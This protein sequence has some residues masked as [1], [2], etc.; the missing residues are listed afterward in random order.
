MQILGLRWA[1]RASELRP[2]LGIQ[3]QE[4]ELPDKLT[5]EEIV[6]EPEMVGERMRSNCAV[7][8]NKMGLEVISFTITR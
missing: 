4:T 8:M 5:V 6:K 2:R 1:E 3:L 7:D